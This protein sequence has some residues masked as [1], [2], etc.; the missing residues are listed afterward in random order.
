MEDSTKPSIAAIV[1]S[2]NRSGLARRALES[3]AAQTLPPADMEIVLVDDGSTDDTPAMAARFGASRPNFRC[4]RQPNR[5]L[6]DARNTGWKNSSAP[7][8]AYLDDD[9]T[10]K[11]DWAACYVE[12]FRRLPQE[13][14]CAGGKIDLDWEAPRPGWLD[15][16]SLGWLGRLDLSPGEI[17]SFTR[18]GLFIGG[19]MALRRDALERIGGFSTRLGRIGETLLSHE[20][21]G[22]LKAAHAL[23]LGTA[24]L[25]SPVIL[26]WVPKARLRQSWFRR[27]LYW[28]GISMARLRS[29]GDMPRGLFLRWLKALN[30][31]RVQLGNGAFLR[32]AVK[33]W[34]WRRNLPWQ[35]HAC[36]QWG[37]TVG[38]LRGK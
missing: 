37:Y 36:Y 3:L 18:G 23:G 21:T 13:I 2:Y 34:T 15:D 6:S 31:L 27:R 5:G 22:L 38:M 35:H 12:A 17:V 10:A 25:P 19:N 29:P 20:E 33:P 24:Y 4:L 32:V 11:P 14:A 1:C 16:G 28:E 9:A 30:Y 7:I 8:I 26:H